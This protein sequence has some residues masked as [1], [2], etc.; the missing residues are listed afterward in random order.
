MYRH[1]K[2]G[3]KSVSDTD[4]LGV[5]FV[6]YRFLAQFKQEFRAACI[7]SKCKDLVH[8]FVD[9][10]SVPYLPPE[11]KCL[12]FLVVSN[13]LTVTINIWT[14]AKLTRHYPRVIINPSR[15]GIIYS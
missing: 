4:A 7:L 6:W 12:Q 3:I 2:I 5:V 9:C 11:E 10:I 13:G 1:L 15:S 14:G 8:F